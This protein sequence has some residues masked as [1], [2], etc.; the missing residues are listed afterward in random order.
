M[1][2]KITIKMVN[3]LDHVCRAIETGYSARGRNTTTQEQDLK[4]PQYV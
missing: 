3:T 1:S 2:E 4:I